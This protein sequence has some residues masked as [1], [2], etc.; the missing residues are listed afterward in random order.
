LEPL[1]ASFHH[2]CHFARGV[3]WRACSTGSSAS[4]RPAFPGSFTRHGHLKTEGERLRFKRR[5][6]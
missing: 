2:I 5:G 4:R 6:S 3:A 1:D